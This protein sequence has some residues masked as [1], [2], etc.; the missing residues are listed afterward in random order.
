MIAP[1]ATVLRLPKGSPMKA[2]ITDPTKAPTAP[3]QPQL[4]MPIRLNEKCPAYS[5][6]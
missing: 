2:V 4:S 6:K 1:A 3:R 5:R